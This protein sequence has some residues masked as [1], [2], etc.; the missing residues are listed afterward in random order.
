VVAADLGVGTGFTGAAR[1]E[2]IREQVMNSYWTYFT[3]WTKLP[4]RVRLFWINFCID[5]SR[6]A[7]Q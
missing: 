4:E 1:R 5:S 2:K 3:H 7:K 6:K